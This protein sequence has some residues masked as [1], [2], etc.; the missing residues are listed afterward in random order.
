MQVSL[1]ESTEKHIRKTKLTKVAGY[2]INIKQP[3]A[4]Q[5]TTNRKRNGSNDQFENV[6]QEKSYTRKSLE[7]EI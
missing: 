4:S 2:K 5:Y 7:K 6:I 1:S 3:I